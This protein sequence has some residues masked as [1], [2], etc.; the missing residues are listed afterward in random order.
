MVVFEVIL[1]DSRD[2]HH[3][4]N[5][6]VLVD[7][8]AMAKCNWFLHGLSAVSETAEGSELTAFIAVLFALVTETADYHTRIPSRILFFYR[9]VV[10][11]PTQHS[12]H[13][14]DSVNCTDY[15]II[16]VEFLS[17]GGQIM[18]PSAKRLSY[19]TDD[20]GLL[21]GSC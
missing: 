1:D 16:S 10:E 11:S 5:T 21:V 18:H 17:F 4:T 9:F 19:R 14:D 15:F 8:L 3:R 12:Y 7:I 20:C 6:E 2:G 13:A